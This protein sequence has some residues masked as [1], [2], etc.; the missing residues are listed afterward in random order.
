MLAENNL[1]VSEFALHAF[2][3]QKSVVR[4]LASF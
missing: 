2:R 3:E 1:A 4:H